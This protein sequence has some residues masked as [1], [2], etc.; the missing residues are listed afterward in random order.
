MP[1][2]TVL[3]CRARKCHLGHPSWE[4]GLAGVEIS[5]T[6]DQRTMPGGQHTPRKRRLERSSCVWSQGPERPLHPQPR[7]FRQHRVQSGVTGIRCP[8]SL[9]I[10]QEPKTHGAPPVAGRHAGLA[11]TPAWRTAAPGGVAPGAAPNQSLRAVTG[12]SVIRHDTARICIMP[13]LQPLPHVAEHVVQAES[14]WCLLADRMGTAA[15]VVGVPGDQ[16]EVL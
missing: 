14:V 13:V 15:A 5:G 6:Y 1:S 4:T 8:V 10:A 16:V 11:I 3:L 7:F 2:R 9:H 12:A